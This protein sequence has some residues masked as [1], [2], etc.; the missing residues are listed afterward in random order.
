MDYRFHAKEWKTLK[1]DE[2]ARRC[3]LLADQAMELANSATDDSRERY[4]AIAKDWLK[5][6]ADIERASR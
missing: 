1:R 4:I 5:L 2:R 3:R 6:A